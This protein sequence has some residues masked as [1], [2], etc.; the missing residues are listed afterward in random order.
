ML[1]QENHYDCNHELELIRAEAVSVRHM[2]KRGAP[3]W[4]DGC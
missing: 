1:I 3:T 2:F 4:T